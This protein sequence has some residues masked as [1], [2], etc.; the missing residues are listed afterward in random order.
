VIPHRTTPG[1]VQWLGYTF[2]GDPGPPYYRWVLHDNTSRSRWLR[3]ALRGTVQVMPIALLMLVVLPHNW[4]TGAS[5]LLG[6]LLALWCSLAYINQAAELRLVN[7]G[8]APGTLAL[9][10]HER[11]LRENKGEIARYHA[12]YRHQNGDP[13]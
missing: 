2:G 5:V 6:L 7:H 10:L 4:L 9:T 1:P 8:F 11:C 12:T 13:A 3:L